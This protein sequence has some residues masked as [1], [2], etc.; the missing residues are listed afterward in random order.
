MSERGRAAAETDGARWPVVGAARRS[1]RLSVHR[2]RDRRIDPGAV[3]AGTVAGH[4]GAGEDAAREAGEAGDRPSIAGVGDRAGRRLHRHV[5]RAT[6][7]RHCAA[8]PNRW[9]GGVN[10]PPAVPFV[11]STVKSKWAVPGGQGGGGLVVEVVV[12]VVVVEVVGAVLVG[13]VLV[14]VE[15]VGVVLVVEVVR[16]GLVVEMGGA[17]VVLVVVVLVVVGHAPTRGRHLRM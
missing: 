10:K 16:I 17:V 6:S 14:V 8:P 3:G 7:Q 15:V 13:D 9:D 1:R 5:A 2:T 4:T 12:V 11:L